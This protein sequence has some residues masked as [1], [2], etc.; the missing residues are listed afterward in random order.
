MFIANVI[1]G[2]FDQFAEAI[3]L[4]GLLLEGTEYLLRQTNLTPALFG[5]FI[6]YQCRKHMPMRYSA[7]LGFMGY[8][9]LWVPVMY[10][11]NDW[12]AN[13]G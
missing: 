10:T 9:F 4:I 11:V 3:R 8:F 13:L 6:C 5:I 1:Q 12:W 2:V 7:F